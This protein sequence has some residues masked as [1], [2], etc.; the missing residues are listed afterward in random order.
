MNWS[1]WQDPNRYGV[2]QGSVA[3]Q[4]TWLTWLNLVGLQTLKIIA[5]LC[6]V[7]HP[8]LGEDFG[9]GV[10]SLSSKQPAEHLSIIASP[11]QWWVARDLA[12]IGSPAIGQAWHLASG[13]NSPEMG[14]PACLPSMKTFR[15]IR[16]ASTGTFATRDNASTKV[17]LC[18][19][20]L[21]LP[22]R[23][24][25]LLVRKG[26]IVRSFT[27][28]YPSSKAYSCTNALCQH[29]GTCCEPDDLD[30]CGYLISPFLHTLTFMFKLLPK[31]C[32]EGKG[33]TLG[34]NFSSLWAWFF[35]VHFGH[36]WDHFG[37]KWDHFGHKRQFFRNSLG[38]LS[39]SLAFTS[40]TQFRLTSSFYVVASNGTRDM[41]P[42]GFLCCCK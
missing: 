15:K 32:H 38:F 28:G 6:I 19:I 13:S 26:K 5:L 24:M 4:L 39:G 20:K 37:H 16:A 7:L 10:S 36:K 22:Q 11:V 12:Q 23:E 31:Y 9:I 25:S 42:L 2:R 8:Q 35:E 34:M 3:F 30:L 27:K 29:L 40:N 1:I 41:T 21:N 33:L 14:I 17:K 18:W